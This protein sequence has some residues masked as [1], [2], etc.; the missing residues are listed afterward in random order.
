M[1][2]R[3]IGGS[4]LRGA[5][6]QQQRHAT[7]SIKDVGLRI[8]SVGSIKKI[9]GAMKM[10]ASAKQ[11]HDLLRMRAGLPFAEPCKRIMDRIP[12][13]DKVEKG[14]CILLGISG[15]KGLC[16]GVNSAI[17]KALKRN[18][19]EIEAGG[20]A[21]QMM[22]IGNKGPAA[23]KRLFGDRF[24]YTFEQFSKVPLN[25]AQTSTVA[26]T[27][28][29]QNPAALKISHNK[30]I[31]M[32][33]Y[34][35]LMFPMVTQADMA[36]MDKL[37]L[38]QALDAYTFEPPLTECGDDFHSFYYACAIFGG[39][40]HGAAAEQSARV[41]AMENASSNAGDMLGALE[42]QY[43]KARQAKITTELCEIVSGASAV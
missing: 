26:A 24:T 32:A 25:F 34:D 1:L 9:T 8:K 13:P 31:N 23:L 11:K 29:A 16:G 39:A 5:L 42:I 14:P 41:T 12:V 33:T 38:S 2:N 22:F 36:E 40:L 19:V 30:Y 6:A 10:V 35:T 7:M 3:A 17:G 20:V 18:A 43:N 27:I 15:D 28:I 4:S 37:E 21:T